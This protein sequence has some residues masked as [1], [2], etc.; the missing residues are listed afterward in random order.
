MHEVIIPK[1]V[2]KQMK[3]M[4][5]PIAGKVKQTIGEI[6]EDPYLGTS[7][8]G[9]LSFL[10]KWAFQEHGVQYRIAYTINDETVEIKIIHIGTRENF[11]HELKRRRGV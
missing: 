7:L 6:A 1:S 11:Y 5:K 4:G 10:R 3:K 9:E 8:K 2:V